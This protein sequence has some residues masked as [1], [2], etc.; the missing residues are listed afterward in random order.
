[1]G[2]GSVEVNGKKYEVKEAIGL[3]RLNLTDLEI[4]E[5][6]EIKG[7]EKLKKVESID[8][9][10]NSL[11]DLNG[12]NVIPQIQQLFANNNQGFGRSGIIHEAR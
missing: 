1:M 9:S 8:L 6:S 10:N 2:Y 7:L 12:L 3:L 5:I 4:K 11:T